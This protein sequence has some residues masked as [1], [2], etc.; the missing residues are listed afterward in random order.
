MNI[1]C[2]G[3]GQKQHTWLIMVTYE[4]M[5]VRVVSYILCE[6]NKPTQTSTHTPVSISAYPP[7]PLPG[8]EWYH[9][10]FV[11]N[12]NQSVWTWVK[13]FSAITEESLMKREELEEA[14][15]DFLWLSYTWYNLKIS[16][17]ENYAIYRFVYTGIYLVSVLT[18]LLK[19]PPPN[20]LP[21]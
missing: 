1:P 8:E 5:Y 21:T 12:R 16:N 14:L 3:Q 20:F 13:C 4:G 17:S 9:K 15:V 10:R 7:S 18:M 6:Q 19:F 11:W 2:D